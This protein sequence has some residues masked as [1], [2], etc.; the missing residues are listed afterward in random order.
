MAAP[1]CFGGAD[2]AGKN[3][4]G[5]LTM[6]NNAARVKYGQYDGLG[7][8]E[9]LVDFGEPAYPFSYAYND[10]MLK[11]ETYP[12]GR[13]VNYAADPAGRVSGVSGTKTGEA[14][15][16]YA[17]GIRYSKYGPIEQMQL[18]NGLWET[19]CFN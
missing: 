18:G 15:R 14:G 10:L 7:R 8:V 6:V 4:T 16:T 9:P 1:P 3:L 13:V 2:G 12:S 11:A 17:S 5:R 19:T